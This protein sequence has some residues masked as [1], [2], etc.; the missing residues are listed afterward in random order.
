[1]DL[2]MGLPGGLQSWT[3]SEWVPPMGWPPL[4]ALLAGLA[5]GG[6]RGW[7]QLAASGWW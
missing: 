7:G 6:L 5:A 2:L 1:M 3:G 4:G